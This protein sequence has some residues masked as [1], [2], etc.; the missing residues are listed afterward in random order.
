M[1]SFL[2][3]FGLNSSLNQQDLIQQIKTMGLQV[4]QTGSGICI[5][6]DKD[7]SQIKS[8]LEKSGFS[9]IKLIPISNQDSELTPDVK[10]FLNS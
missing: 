5:K 2:I 10:S 4:I 9:E 6:G 1:N 3:N 7:G 8:D